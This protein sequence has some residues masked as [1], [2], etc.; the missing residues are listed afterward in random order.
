MNYKS[1][2]AV[3]CASMFT[4]QA[5]AN[6]INNQS[7]LDKYQELS[8]GH[9]VMAAFKNVD[10]FTEFSS[11]KDDDS[12]DS[13]Q[14]VDSTNAG[15]YGRNSSISEDFMRE[16]GK[17]SLSECTAENEGAVRY[18]SESVQHCRS[19]I[20]ENVDNFGSSNSM[21]K[22]K[23]ENIDGAAYLVDLTNPSAIKKFKLYF[24]RLKMVGHNDSDEYSG[25]NPQSYSGASVY[26]TFISGGKYYYQYGSRSYLLEQ[27]KSP[28]GTVIY[29]SIEGSYGFIH[30]WSSN[31][32][33]E[34]NRVSFDCEI[35]SDGIPYIDK[36]KYSLSRW[37][38]DDD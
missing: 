6:P 18:Q 32:D 1:Y 2:F 5:S 15:I 36:P 31:G 11:D 20:W 3:L 35:G 21:C 25:Y 9:D 4:L 10:Q 30:S 14:F 23:F 13:Y 12:S 19:G 7:Q 34:S 38:D 26:S 29:K 16:V 22:A 8:K 33:G 24:A 28:P 37:D 17:L 27:W